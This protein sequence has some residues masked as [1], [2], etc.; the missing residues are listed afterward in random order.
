[1][2][3][4]TAAGGADPQ[5]AAQTKYTNAANTVVQMRMR[6]DELRAMAGGSTEDLLLYKGTRL[7]FQRDP[8]GSVFSQMTIIG[9]SADPQI[10]GVRFDFANMP[11]NGNDVVLYW[12]LLSGTSDS[13]NIWIGTPS[14]T[15][16]ASGTRAV[17]GTTPF[18][19]Q[20]GQGGALEL[21][22]GCFDSLALLS[23]GRT[24]SARW[25]K[26]ESTDSDMLGLY[27]FAEGTGSTTA[28]ATG[29]TAI[30]VNSGS[31]A[32]GG[33]WNADTTASARFRP[34]FITG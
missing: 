33:T 30:T 19:S 8:D 27:Y 15:T 13:A 10:L 20:S 34:Y 5:V 11:A 26:P 17:V 21:R 7:N 18:A 22:F 32:T 2:S 14:G 3:Y 31:W 25:A 29:G 23:A 1:M 16:I 24:G 9:P 12:E 28:D 6:V 4:L